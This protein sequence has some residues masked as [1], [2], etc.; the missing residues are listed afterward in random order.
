MSVI[1]KN[2]NIPEFFEDNKKDINFKTINA[3]ER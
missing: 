1:I 3:A 2:V